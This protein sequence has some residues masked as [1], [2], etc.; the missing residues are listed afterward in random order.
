MRV[1]LYTFVHKAQRFHMFRLSEKIG[2]TDFSVALET[3]EAA[4]EVLHLLEHLKDHAHNEEKYIHPLYQGVGATGEHFDREHEGL[5]LEIRKLE[6]VIAEKRWSDLYRAYT[7]FLGIYLLHLD[8]E[9]A[10]QRDILWTKYEDKDLAAVFT[11]FKM[12][13]PANLASAD[14]VFMLPALS[15]PELTQMFRGMKASAPAP[16]FKGAC[17]TAAKVLAPNRWQKIAANI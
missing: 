17:D 11:R 16:V 5:E 4:Q 15:I 13:R 2:T 1:D 7:R 12:E 6:S 9:E 8:E 14:F 3:H 10:A